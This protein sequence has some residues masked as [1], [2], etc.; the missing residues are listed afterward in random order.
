MIFHLGKHKHRITWFKTENDLYPHF[1]CVCKHESSLIVDLSVMQTCCC[2]DFPAMWLV[3]LIVLIYHSLRLQYMLVMGCIQISQKG[4]VSKMG[5]QAV[6]DHAGHRQAWTS[7][8]MP[9]PQHIR[10]EPGHSTAPD[11]LMWLFLSGV[12]PNDQRS[13]TP[14]P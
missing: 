8:F 13:T 10:L 11:M 4:C 12:N 3:R 14:G 1:V 2:D 6:S 9:R 5:Q 7:C